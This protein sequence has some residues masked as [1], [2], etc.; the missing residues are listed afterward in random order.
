MNHVLL[1]CCAALALASCQ[2]DSAKREDAPAKQPPAGSAGKPQ[3]PVQVD[4]EVGASSA[5]VSVRFDQAGTGVDVIASGADGLSV[6]G[7]GALAKGR[8]VAAGE[9]DSFDVQFT[10][11]P[12]QSLLV[13]SVRGA[14]AAG[15]RVAVRAFPV[16]KPSAEQMNKA[17][18]GTTQ[19]GNEPVKLSPA[20]EV[21]K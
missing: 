20:D 11:G 1:I 14:F 9:T 15:E 3:A 4:A 17:D 13:I 7:G 16:G 19:I 8:T 10:P 2:T 6:P 21:K 12:G 18:A 5:R